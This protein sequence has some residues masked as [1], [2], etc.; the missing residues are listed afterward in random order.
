[1]SI[2]LTIASI[3]FTHFDDD[4]THHLR[5]LNNGGLLDTLF[6]YVTL[7]GDATFMVF[8]IALFVGGAR[9]EAL[10]FA[11]VFIVVNILALSFKYVIARPRTG[12]LGV[13]PEA[14]VSFPSAHAANAFALQRPFRVT[15]GNSPLSCSRGQ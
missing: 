11:I 6:T 3:Y 7:T 5:D 8:I 9:K 10:V 2:L 1:M 12:D 13:I 14:E 15:I 4:L